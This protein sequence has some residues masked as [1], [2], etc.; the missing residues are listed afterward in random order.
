LPING[1]IGVICI[2]ILLRFIMKS[3]VRFGRRMLLVGAAIAGTTMGIGLPA[4]ALP[5]ATV[6]KKLAP[7]PM[8]MLIAENGPLIFDVI[9]GQAGEDPVGITGVFVNYSDAENF[10]TRRRQEVSAN[11]TAERAKPKKDDAAIQAL[12][13]ESAFW[14][15]VST[16][17]YGLD[18]LYQYGQSEDSKNLRFQFFPSA[19]QMT[20]VTE[21]VGKD[22][23]FRGVPLYYASSPAEGGNNNQVTYPTIP[24]LNPDLT[25]EQF[26]TCDK[27][28][29]TPAVTDDCTVE[30]IPVFFE[31]ESMQQLIKESNIDPSQVSINVLPLEV[32]IASLGNNELSAD[33]QKLLDAMTLVPSV[34]S[35]QL[36]QAEVQRRT[37]AAKVN[38]NTNA[39]TNSNGNRNAN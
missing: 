16:Q 6:L 29:K 7:V 39:S 17:G 1:G 22:E 13:E 23:P 36:I 9:E 18:Q 38:G 5:E 12:T 3:L 26:K 11:L 25:P 14:D 33:D 10:L 15:K 34:E 21:L 19:Q 2:V 30:R 28:E 35:M 27:D 37:E 20:N 4:L 31:V 8:Y 24:I 32:F